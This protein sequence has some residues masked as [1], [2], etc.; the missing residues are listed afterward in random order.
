[1]NIDCVEE[2]IIIITILII[3]DG[4]ELSIELAKQLRV[5]D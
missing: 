4:D 1:M 5:G 2:I 3:I